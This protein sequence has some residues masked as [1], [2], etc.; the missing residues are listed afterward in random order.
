MILDTVNS[1]EMQAA[2]L[3]TGAAM[4]GL[5]AAPLFRQRAQQARLATLVL[6]V[7]GIIV[8]FA[9]HIWQRSWG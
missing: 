2:R 4:V 3:L 9:C 7:V 6:Y 5:L 8:F 1:T